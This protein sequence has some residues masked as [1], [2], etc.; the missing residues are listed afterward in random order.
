MRLSEMANR[1]VQSL[2][3]DPYW[4]FQDRD[5]IAKYLSSQSIPAFPEIVELQVEYSGKT[6]TLSGK[7]SSSFHIRLFSKRDILDGSELDMILFNGQCYFDCGSHET[8]QYWFVVGENGTFGTYSQEEEYVNI[9]SSDFTNLVES[10]ALENELIKKGFYE[11]EQY[12][13][14]SSLSAIQDIVTGLN[15]YESIN[16]QYMFWYSNSSVFLNIAKFY[17]TDSYYL[18]VFGEK[19]IYVKEF[20]TR[21]SQLGAI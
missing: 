6:L 10:Y 3:I 7:P 1:Y 4:S 19:K 8:A 12:F 2:T 18:H 9:L 14:I 13:E 15:K 16:D 21:L 11:A 20:I 5:A 17:G